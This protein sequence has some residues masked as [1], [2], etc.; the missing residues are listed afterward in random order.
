VGL[1]PCLINLA[2]EKEMWLETQNYGTSDCIECG[3][4]NY[5]CPANRNLV[6]SIKRA[7]LEAVK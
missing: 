6:Q 3:L 2:S 4:C 1:M 5:V 7:K